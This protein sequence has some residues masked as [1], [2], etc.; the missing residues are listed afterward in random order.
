MKT[1]NKSVLIWYSPREMYDLVT[2]VKR[3][4]EFLPWCDGARI[5][6]ETGTG[7]TAELSISFGGVRQTF[8]TRNVHTTYSQVEMELLN[9]PFSHLD[10]QWSFVALGDGSQRACKVELAVN[11]RMNSSTLGKLAAPAIDK[12]ASDLVGAFVKRAEQ[13]YGN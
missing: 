8:T 6:E 11:Y 2:D 12:I 1:V 13:V 5:I 3:Y 7:M 4:S 9:G 10:G